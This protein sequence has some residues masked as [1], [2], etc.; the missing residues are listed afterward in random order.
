MDGTNYTVVIFEARQ[1]SPPLS[2]PFDKRVQP[3]CYHALPPLLYSNSVTTG[4]FFVASIYP[5]YLAVRKPTQLQQQYPAE[6][7]EDL[8]TFILLV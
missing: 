3:P 2:L 5:F 6:L 4:R 7:I 1:Q 8:M